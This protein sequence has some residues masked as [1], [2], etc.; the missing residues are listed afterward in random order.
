[1][2][3]ACAVHGCASSS[4]PLV[5]HHTSR[6]CV[7]FGIRL[8]ISRVAPQAT[9]PCEPLAVCECGNNFVSPRSKVQSK[10]FKV[11]TPRFMSSRLPQ[12]ELSH[13]NSRIPGILSCSLRCIDGAAPCIGCRM[14]APMS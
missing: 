11:P 1:M 6:T 2:H 3:A 8:K 7:L 4:V 13:L 5:P 9:Y 12:L 10:K 14:Q